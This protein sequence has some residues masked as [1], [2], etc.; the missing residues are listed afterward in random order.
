[1]GWARAQG[2]HRAHTPD[3]IQALPPLLITTAS[4][5][6][7]PDARK[8]MPVPRRDSVTTGRCLGS[9]WPTHAPGD[10]SRTLSQ[11]SKAPWCVGGGTA[12]DRGFPPRI[13]TCGTTAS[14]PRA[15]AQPCGDRSMNPAEDSALV[16]FVPS[17]CGELAGG[18]GVTRPARSGTRTQ[19]AAARRDFSDGCP[20]CDRAL[21]PRPRSRP[22]RRCE[23]HRFVLAAGS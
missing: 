1:M 23:R 5:P 15:V 9:C 20:T 7:G 4:A 21:R 16:D 6:K 13:R 2:R 11:A 3:G 14:F 18:L 12:V 22:G 19:A 17:L 10:Q 8:G